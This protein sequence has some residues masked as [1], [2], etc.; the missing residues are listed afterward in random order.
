MGT[1]SLNAKLFYSDDCL[2]RE[3]RNHEGKEAGE[4]V[5]WVPQYHQ[6]QADK[7]REIHSYGLG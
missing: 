3:D 1:K 2:Q 7:H 5:A 6:R 4:A